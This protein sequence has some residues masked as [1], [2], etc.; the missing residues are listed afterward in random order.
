MNRLEIAKH[1]LAEL[2]RQRQDIVAAWLAG[3]VARGE[4]TALSDID[5]ALM[6]GGTG[7]VNRAGF[8]TWCEGIYIEAGL[9]YQQ[10]Y[11]DLEA[12]LNNPFQATHM[13]DALIL[14]DPT[15][16][17]T[18]LQNAVRPVFM[19]PQWLG[20][21]LAYWVASARTTHTQFQEAVLAADTLR[22]CAVLGMFTLSCASIPILRA[23]ITPSSSR[24][25]VQLTAL[26]PALKA[27]I[28]AF[29]GST[30]MTAGDVQALEPLLQ[31]MILWVDP[32]YGQLPLY[33]IRKALWMAQQGDPQ[34]A[35]HA[36]WLVML[37][38]AEGC[39]QRHDPAI[40][41]TGRDLTRRW[42]QQTGMSEPASLAGTLQSAERLLQQV[43]VLAGE[44]TG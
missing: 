42:L 3:S 43:K 8:D 40:L 35:L 21:R 2:L 23:G 37:V 19:Q 17:V 6:V 32:A 14:Y 4:E 7:V 16:F 39:L 38:A 41:A 25:L 24:T 22:I 44:S 36:L 20:K 31:A 11:A 10:D 13:N 15:S 26:D 9:V 27:Q 30:H 33:F 1:Y 18:R 34:A 5:L 12:V 28:A 29:E